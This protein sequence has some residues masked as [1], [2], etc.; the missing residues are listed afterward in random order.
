MGISDP[1]F[2]I[3]DISNELDSLSY[4]T[5]RRI[6]RRNGLESH[7]AAKKTLLTADRKAQRVQY[8]QSMS[9]FHSWSSVIFVDESM[10]YTSKLGPKCVLR[11]RSTRFNE[12]FL[13]LIDFSGGC[14]VSVF[15]ALTS[16]GLGPLMRIQGHLNSEKYCEILEDYV[17]FLQEKFPDDNFYWLQ[18]NCPVHCSNES[19]IFIRLNFRGGFINHPPYSPDLNPIENVWGIVK[20]ELKNFPKPATQMNYSIRYN[21][22]GIL[23][24]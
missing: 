14:S 23:L 12:E 3:T 9:S 24:V 4:P 20:T 15:G 7:I 17:L 18:D 19:M 6:L 8:C 2:T 13:N 21:V 1:F 16:T 11:S 10:F 22:F 5:V